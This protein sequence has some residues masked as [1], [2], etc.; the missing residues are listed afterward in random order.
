MD[1]KK[2]NKYLSY[3]Y[4]IE[5]IFIPTD[6][7]GGVSARIPFLGRDAF[8]GDGDTVEE[9]L[10]NL[11]R[12]KRALFEDYI[13]KG[14]DIPPPPTSEDYSGKFVVRVPKLLHRLLV[15]EA[16]R[17]GVSLNTYC[18]SILSQNSPL[19]KLELALTNLCSE[20]GEIKSKVS[21]YKYED[22]FKRDYS[23]PYAYI[24]DWEIKSA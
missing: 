23:S 20:I 19:N 15:E 2:L 5:I 22:S 16:H 9:A 10:A 11:N 17:N 8:V 24:G 14:I 6:E 1:T 18:V 13:K 4:P 12:L 21:H 7:G 3:N